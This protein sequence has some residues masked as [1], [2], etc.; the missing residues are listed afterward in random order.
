MASLL[1]L[2][3]SFHMLSSVEKQALYPKCHKTNNNFAY[4]YDTNGDYDSEIKIF[5]FV[6]TY[7]KWCLNC[8]SK[9]AQYRC[10]G[11]K[12]VYFCS[13]KCQKDSWKVHQKHCGRNIFAYCIGCAKSV[14]ISNKCDK[15]PVRFCSDKCR[16]DLYNAHRDFDCDYFSKTFGEFYLNH[17]T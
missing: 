7:D 1:P 14:D 3:I 17:E 2:L 9:D 13:K 8:P 10:A 11:C 15:C 5:N 6:P 12:A 4:K 16:K